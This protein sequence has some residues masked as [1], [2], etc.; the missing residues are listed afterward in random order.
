MIIW[1]VGF[2]FEVGNFENLT[3]VVF[4]FITLE[5]FELSVHNGKQILLYREVNDCTNK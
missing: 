4:D 1:I 2:N 3:I 5:C